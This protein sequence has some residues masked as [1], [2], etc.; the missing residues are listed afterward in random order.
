MELPGKASRTD[1]VH[2]AT[3]LS[4]GRDY[5]GI[6]NSRVSSIIAKSLKLLNLCFIIYEV[7]LL[8]FSMMMKSVIMCGSGM[9][10]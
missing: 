4:G 1:S 6:V 5:I 2:F 7:N 8:A 3:I 10:T 9:R